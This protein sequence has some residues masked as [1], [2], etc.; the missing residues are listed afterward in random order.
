MII[1]T[2]TLVLD[3]NPVTVT[4]K[5]IENNNPSGRYKPGDTI[6]GKSA[7]GAKFGQQFTVFDDTGKVILKTDTVKQV[8]T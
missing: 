8:I 1:K 4:V 7:Q 2:G 3:L 5:V 6:Q